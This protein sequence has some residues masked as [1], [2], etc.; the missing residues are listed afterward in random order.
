[1]KLLLLTLG[2]CFFVSGCSDSVSQP[3][4]GYPIQLVLVNGY[5]APGNATAAFKLQVVKNQAAL[6][7]AKLTALQ[8]PSGR[9]DTVASISDDTGF[10]LFTYPMTNVDQVAFQAV[11]DSLLSNYVRWP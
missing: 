3:P 10:F 6:K 8:Y 4:T 7:G 1:M 5:R 11:K 2:L 9:L